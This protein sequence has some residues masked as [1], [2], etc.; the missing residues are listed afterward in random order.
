M[1]Y[2]F[3]ANRIFKQPCNWYNLNFSAHWRAKRLLCC[4]AKVALSWLWRCTANRRE[5]TLISDTATSCWKPPLRSWTRRTV[6][7]MSVRK[8]LPGS[9]A[10]VGITGLWTKW[11]RGIDSSLSGSSGHQEDRFSLSAASSWTWLEARPLSCSKLNHVYL[12]ILSI[13]TP[14]L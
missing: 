10:P 3:W 11:F 5:W 12:V 13:V 1:F 2:F 8:L 14:Y 9:R 4:T 6:Q 7:K